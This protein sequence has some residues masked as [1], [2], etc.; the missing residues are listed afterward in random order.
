MEKPTLNSYFL[1][2]ADE[3]EDIN[4]IKAENFIFYHRA[5]KTASC[6]TLTNYT[7]TE[8]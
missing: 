8:K 2:K 5:L 3:G 1:E 4:E 6:A 7:K